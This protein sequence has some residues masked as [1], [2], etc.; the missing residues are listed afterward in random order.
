ML[1]FSCQ[2]SLET[3]PGMFP[4]RTPTVIRTLISS[5]HVIPNS[6]NSILHCLYRMCVVSNG[7]AI[8]NLHAVNDI[9]SLPRPP[10]DCTITKV[11]LTRAFL[12]GSQPWSHT[13]INVTNTS[14]FGHF[15]ITI[16]I[17][18]CYQIESFTV[19]IS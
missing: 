6:L 13:L 1:M 17:C 7:F 18:F 2:I 8:V 16:N 12:Q 19:P 10:I 15:R 4:N 3:T 5:L 14:K 11:G 9:V